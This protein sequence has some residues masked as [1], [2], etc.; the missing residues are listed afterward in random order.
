MAIGDELRR[1]GAV[2][3]LGPQE[4]SVSQ[5]TDDISLGEQVRQR[6]QAQDRQ[7]IDEVLS[8]VP[9]I[10]GGTLGQAVRQESGEVPEDDA[11]T[12]EGA[13]SPSEGQGLGNALRNFFGALEQPGVRQALSQ[14]GI[15][16]GGT[17]GGQQAQGQQAQGQQ[18]EGGGGLG[19]ILGNRDVQR[20]LIAFGSSIGGEDAVSEFGNQLISRQAQR[21]FQQRLQERGEDALSERVPGLTSE[22][23]RSVLEQFRG[24]QQREIEN[25]LARREQS[26]RERETEADIERAEERTEL[27]QERLELQKVKE[28]FDQVVT[29]EQ[30]SMRQKQLELDRISQQVDNAATRARIGLTEAR[31]RLVQAQTEGEE[32]EQAQGGRSSSQAAG[33]FIDRLDFVRQSTDTISELLQS[34]QEQ[35]RNLRGQLRLADSEEGQEAIRQQLQEA[36]QRV[37]N[38]QN[39][40]VQN[41]EA[42]SV[43]V[44]QI[45]GGMQGSQGQEQE[46]QSTGVPA[47]VKEQARQ[48]FQQG[49]I[50][51]GDTLNTVDGT[52]RLI[53]EDGV[54]KIQRV[55][56]DGN[57]TSF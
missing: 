52:F 28:R 6:Q 57:R 38:L 18:Q 54:P 49:N 30:L 11:L 23:R 9:G 22:G 4:L 27:E 46:Q 3:I 14:L 37:T 32:A 1:D 53:E 55:S 7:V 33:D 41:E 21:D 39:Q 51:V 45:T 40:L 31:T 44:Q 5:S 8:G 34:A 24:E 56:T 17:G 48:Q 15:N 29:N 19:S 35:Q 20:A 12:P 16:L 10:A 42:M 50:S 2:P 26:R 25:Q 36:E 47:A 43:A 13:V